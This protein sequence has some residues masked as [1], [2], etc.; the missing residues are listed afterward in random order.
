ML[1]SNLLFANTKN[2]GDL[3]YQ[4]EESLVPEKLDYAHAL[5]TASLLLSG[6]LILLPNIEKLKN[7]SSERGLI[8][9]FY[10]LSFLAYLILNKQL[11]NKKD[12]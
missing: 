10:A 2:L 11:W 9:G 5:F 8:F 4:Q 1:I 6:F 12:E 3:S 7:L